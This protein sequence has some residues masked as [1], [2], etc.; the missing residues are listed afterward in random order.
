M[1][2]LMLIGAF[3]ALISINDIQAQ[4]EHPELDYYEVKVDGLGCPFCAFGLEKK[5]KSIKGIKDIEIDLEE[6]LMV[7]YLPPEK[8]MSIEDVEERVDKAGYTATLTKIKRADGTKE[9]SKG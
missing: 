3:V 1:K 8:T 9:K 2:Y 7:F 5:F 6:G 4:T